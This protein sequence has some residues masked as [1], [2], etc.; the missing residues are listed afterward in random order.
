MDARKERLGEVDMEAAA[1]SSGRWGR[2]RTND[3]RFLPR[4]Q[5][6]HRSFCIPVIKDKGP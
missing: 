1:K 4:P 5:Q 6:T 2:L 3:A